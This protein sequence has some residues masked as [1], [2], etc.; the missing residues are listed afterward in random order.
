MLEESKEK[1]KSKFNIPVI[2]RFLLFALMLVLPICIMPFSWDWSERSMSLCILGFSTIIIGLETIKL[3][4]EGKLSIIKTSLDAGMFLLLLSM[5][6]STI[7]SKDINTSFWGIDGRLGNSLTIF[8]SLIL[9][10]ISARSFIDDAKYVKY[11]F[12]SFLIGLSI[13]N[14]LSIFSFLGVNIWGFI[15]VYKDL[16]QTGLPLLRSAKIHLLINI[17]GGMLSL[18][19]IGA[20]LIS[21]SK[22]ST[23]VISSIALILSI[24]NIW[25][26]SISQG[27]YLVSACLLFLLIFCIF[28]IKKLKL[29]P[30]SSKN[31][32]LVF[33]I[34]ILS[35]SVPFVLL[36]IPSL[37]EIIIPDS[38]TLVG[39]VSLGS[40]V[41]WIIASSSLVSSLI[42]GIFGLGVDTY[43]IAYNLYKP[44]TTSLLAY[45]GVNFYYAGNEVFTQ[46]SNGGLFWLVAWLFLG[47]L[48]SKSLVSDINKIRL[49]SD[50]TNVWYLILIDFI[51]LFIYI[52]AIITT[53]AV[54]ILFLFILLIS[55]R[56]ILKNTLSKGT[57]DKLVLK[58]WAINLNNSSENTKPNQNVSTFISIFI[59]ITMCCILIFWSSK[60]ISSLYILK[61]ESYY[62]EQNAKYANVEPTI[63][64]RNNFVETMTNYYTK[65]V[66]FDK[67]NP[68]ANRKQG[69]MYLER[70][71]IAAEEYSNTDKEELD[72]QLISNVGQWKNYAID[73]TRK[74]IDESE[75]VYA[76]WEARVKV[77]MGLVGMG[78][79]DYISDSIYSLEKAIEL[80]PLNYELYYSKA[81]I[82]VI[83]DETDNALSA[84][85]QEL[86]INSQHIPSIVMAADLN[87]EKGNMEIYESYLKA[88]KKILE[89]QGN[90]G[91]E[92]YKE[93][94]NKLVELNNPTTEE[95]EEQVLDTTDTTQE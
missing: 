88:A 70:V 63:E 27:F 22:K 54:I 45:N 95:T 60:I 92:V 81:Q 33:I 43:T 11:I 8:I 67:N 35:I 3:I 58:L 32:L 41:S 7:F 94:S 13:N 91:Y 77:Y 86:S 55:I 76:N 12:I 87:K 23:V 83:N 2:Q 20:S 66:K 14:I 79:Y 50:K 5:L 24:I 19:L 51:L 69:L 65:A 80:N 1:K 21:E 75:F 30:T 40:D 4:W 39:Q 74:S 90:T 16:N 48:I 46:I 78:F 53:Y 93:V 89:T 42:T 71:G 61:A 15:P 37:R 64:E 29:T 82:Y 72:S 6:L 59:S 47:F 62:T 68:L 44:L 18:G 17:I 85:T 56:G 10:S 25:M 26:Y 84:L 34:V 57:E 36:Q 52:S 38:I 9:L 28:F 73:A 31:I 49:Y